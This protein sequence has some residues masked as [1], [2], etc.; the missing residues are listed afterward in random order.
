[1]RRGTTTATVRVR[2]V[3]RRDALGDATYPNSTA[4]SRTRL[5]VVSEMPGTP[6]RA[7]DTVEIETPARSA[8]AWTETVM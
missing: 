7:R 3:A 6:R 5:H 4:A 2:P 1:M 8:T